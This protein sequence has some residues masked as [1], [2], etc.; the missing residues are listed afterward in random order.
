METRHLA[1]LALGMSAPAVKIGSGPGLTLTTCGSPSS[2]KPIGSL[3]SHALPFDC[4]K[5]RAATGLRGHLHLMVGVEAQIR[6]V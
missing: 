2:V 4:P 6:E 3:S 1:S 5:H